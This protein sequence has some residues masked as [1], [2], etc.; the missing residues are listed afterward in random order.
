M[1]AAL[2]VAVAVGLA[3]AVPASAPAAQP[4]S[5]RT[6]RLLVLLD[7]PSVRAAVLALPGLR[8]DGAEVPQIGLLTVRPVGGQLLA[9]LVPLLRRLPG[10][11]SVQFER[12]H[13]LRILPNDPALTAPE[14]SAGTPPGTML[15]WWIPRLNAPAAW[16]ITRGAGASVAVIDTGIDGGHPELQGKVEQAI[17][18]DDT[19]NTGP[20]TA[21]EIGHGTHV[22]SIAC[23]AGDN[24]QGLVGVGLDCKLIVIKSD[25]SDGSLARSVVKAA[26][27]DAGAVNMSFGT[28]GRVPPVQAVVEAVDYAVA[29]D[30]VLVAAAADSPVE[31]Q[32]DPANLL[33]TTGTGPD[34]NSSR[35]LVVTSADFNGQ[36]SPFAGRGS[37][38]SMASFGSF[39]AGS[40]PPGLFGAFPGNATELESGGS[41]LFPKPACNCRSQFNGDPRFA[42]LQG[43]SMAAPMVTAAA[44]LMRNLNPDLTAADVIR[45]LKQTAA[46]PAG[47]GWSPDLGWGILDVGA[48]V[49]AARAID[50][51][52]PASRLSGPAR[53]RTARSF[54]IRWSG[55]DQ[56][57]PGLEP[58]GIEAYDVYRSTNRRPYKRIAR[59]AELRMKVSAR[60]GSRYRFYT[61][62]G[63]RAG[64]REAVP[65][66]PDLSVRVI[67]TRGQALAARR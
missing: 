60:A 39:V 30:T 26:D 53:V 19:P 11:R 38:I 67:R 28:S 4:A 27:L 23:A 48:A 45:V 54:T 32:G 6:G 55:A 44:A 31:E 21:D 41:L 7:N 29:K 64:N 57:P 8:A 63:D 2:S 37:Q 25:L 9:A 17:D 13:A 34:I 22:A 56:A 51:R 1:P 18:L 14:V 24:G 33:Q 65:P 43:T 20:A 61:L 16:D 42:Y 49:G 52:S 40:G 59:T 46:R 12:R 3:L 15:Q 36:R 10:V 62:A 47:S 50:R 58:S 35:G 66:R 5:E